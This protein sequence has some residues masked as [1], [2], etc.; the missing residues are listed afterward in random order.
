MSDAFT[1]HEPH[2]TH[3]DPLLDCL[4]I[5]SKLYGNPYTKESLKAGL[6]LVDDCLTPSL[7][8][9][10]A[11]RAGLSAKIVSKRLPTIS[12]LLLPCI[13]I[14]KNN[15]AVVLVGIN[16]T[17]KS[18]IIMPPETDGGEQEIS[19][20]ELWKEYTGYSIFV[21]KAH[22]F[23]K[24]TDAHRLEKPK[25]WFWDT[26]FRYKRQLYHVA[27]ATFLINLF[28][29]ASPLFVMNV[30]DRVVPNNAMYTLWALAI[31]IS[32]VYFFDFLF[33]T[34]RSHL[35]D[36]RGKKTDVIL[37]SLIM[38]Q[39]LSLR[40]SC[41]PK[42]VGGFAN[43]INSYEF[44]RDFFTSAT[45]VGLIDLPFVFLFLWFVSFIGGELVL[46][47]I[48]A[49]PITI[50]ISLLL[51]IPIRKA[52]EKSYF[53]SVQ[54]N[55]LLIESLISLEAI[56]SLNA[57]GQMQ[58]K[59]ENCVSIVTEANNESKFFSSIAV[60]VT[61][62]II[63]MVTV[64]TVI[65]GVFLISEGKLT[66]GGLI[67]CNLLNGRTLAP[68]AQ[69]ASIITKFQQ[70]K[71]GL[72]GLNRIMALPTER[73]HASSFLHRPQING[74]IKIID[75]NFVYPDQTQAA[76]EHINLHI[77]PKEKVAIIGK[78]G[79]GKS[80]L[81]K[82]ILGLYFANTGSIRIDDTE[83]SQIDPVDLRRHFGYVGQDTTLFYGTVRANMTAATP[84]ASDEE[85]LQAAE[86]SGVSEFV[87]RHPKGYDMDTGERGEFL[88]SGQR[89]AIAIAR[90][91]VHDPKILLLDE[92]TSSMD[93]TTEHIFLDKFQRYC[94]DKTLILITHKQSLLKLVDRII[95]M[96][97][98]K[99]V[100]DG[101]K[102][103][104]LEALAKGDV[105]TQK[106]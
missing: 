74:D 70:S 89:Q 66:M 72:S 28:A 54:K 37:A 53:G 19:L 67:A 105:K 57:E 45:L 39:L 46:I 5:T 48:F 43:Q 64:I 49:I 80:T 101:P 24:R 17:T 104:V 31:G 12:Q 11:S 29:L 7:F 106:N 83:I 50:I 59:W 87:H 20:K 85:I 32:L 16:H 9:R 99:I 44:L 8:V 2:Q 14:L 92:P 75:A 94:Q 26:I 96:D 40:L 30:Y 3:L 21:K 65:Y 36:N 90:A 1:R 95:I 6:P 71:L 4:V 38:Q 51:E 35:I 10:A 84:W 97:N 62:Y 73:E 81:H 60:N 76:L 58:R 42:S 91:I 61:N 86:I 22:H 13:L 23:E 47:P 34:I 18:A 98:G 68:L 33:K 102:Q 56:K 41:K 15:H 27:I 55:A 63:Q 52:T 78:I 82:L 69:I 25:S 103:A 93:N 88:S 79:S 100:I 77:K